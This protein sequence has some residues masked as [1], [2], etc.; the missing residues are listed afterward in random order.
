MA[1]VKRVRSSSCT[2]SQSGTES[3]LQGI[4][5]ELKGACEDAISTCADTV[6]KHIRAYLELVARHHSSGEKEPLTGEQ[7]GSQK[8]VEDLIAGFVELCHRDLRNAVARLRLY[9]EDDRTVNVLVKH[10]QETIIDEYGEF[11][12]VVWTEYGEA[13]SGA[14]YNDEAVRALLRE[15]CEVEDASSSQTQ[16]GGSDSTH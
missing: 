16:A 6:C 13:L 7:W 3:S 1:D 14:V 11:R 15:V 9:L 5:N 8:A 4:D 2:H 12:R 10:A